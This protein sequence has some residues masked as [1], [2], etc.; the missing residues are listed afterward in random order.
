MREEPRIGAVK[1][2]IDEGIMTVRLLLL[3]ILVSV[4]TGSTSAE[5]AGRYASVRHAMLGAETGIWWFQE[6]SGLC[7][8]WKVASPLPSCFHEAMSGTE[9]KVLP[10]PG[11]QTTT[12]PPAPPAEL[13]DELLAGQVDSAVSLR[14]LYVMPVTDVELV[15]PVRGVERSAESMLPRCFAETHRGLSGQ[16]HCQPTRLL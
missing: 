12:P 9:R 1:D 10:I 11:N 13:I 5:K 16:L 7:S 14:V 6:D 15:Q 4:F 2:S 3:F 8:R